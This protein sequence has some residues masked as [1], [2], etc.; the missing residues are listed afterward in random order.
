MKK[1]IKILITGSA[2]FVGTN[3]IQQISKFKKYKIT[4]TYNKK[5]PTKIKNISYKKV[6]LLDKKKI[7]TLIKKQEIIIHLAGKLGTK[8]ILKKSH[9]AIM[10][11]NINISINIAN[12]AY[13][14][15]ISKFIWLSSTTGY[16]DRNFLKEKFFFQGEC[17]KDYEPIGLY[18]RFF[19]KLLKYYNRI[20]NKKF[21]VIILRPSIIFGEFDDF[22]PL[23][24]HFLPSVI[25]D[26]INN[27]TVYLYN[28]GKIKRDWLYVNDLV[29]IMIN[30]VSRKD[31]NSYEVFNVGSNQ[32]ISNGNII[33]KIIKILK[34]NKVKIQN[35]YVS[36]K[37]YVTQSRLFDLAKLKKLKLINK[38]NN[39]DRNLNRTI[40]WYKKNIK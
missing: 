25:Y 19:E 12:S 34:K 30:L 20:S 22:N 37:E 26:I 40:N 36:K 29:R 23:T 21:R 5:K 7:D 35:K 6:N 4:A 28:D 10:K 18:C 13:K 39:F 2:G 31:L 9:F 14:N 8:K 15:K 11:Q 38:I 1:K 16:P 33:N 27:R 32:R 17:L 24:A 3:F